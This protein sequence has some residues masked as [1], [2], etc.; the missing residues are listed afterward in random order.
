[1]DFIINFVSRWSIED[2]DNSFENSEFEE[3]VARK[4]QRILPA[5]NFYF[6]NTDIFVVQ[7]DSFL[8]FK[9]FFEFFIIENFSELMF[10]LGFFGLILAVIYAVIMEI[11]WIS[12]FFNSKVSPFFV[13]NFSK[14]MT[15]YFSTTLEFSIN[16]LYYYGL[17]LSFF[18]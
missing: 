18:Y 15:F 11:M 1:M 3:V 10:F 5:D 4:L 17:F 14:N 6:N 9:S 16:S 2:Y 12:Q 8:P 7:I 13:K